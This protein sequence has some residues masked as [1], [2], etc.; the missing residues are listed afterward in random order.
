MRGF[1]SETS[2]RLD[3]D[4][5]LLPNGQ[6][7]TLA[8]IRQWQADLIEGR[9]DLPGKWSGRATHARS[10]YPHARMDGAGNQPAS[11]AATLNRAAC[12]DRNSAPVHACRPDV[13]G[14]SSADRTERTRSIW[15]GGITTG[16][17][18]P[19]RLKM[20]AC[21]KMRWLMMMSGCHAL[22]GSDGHPTHGRKPRRQR[23]AE[24]A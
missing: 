16:T 5:R 9:C 21:W 2:W 24:P 3:G 11:V 13:S 12:N 17:E 18:S 10:R 7:L 22:D 1:W 19:A 6:R 20:R 8:S 4:A 23:L 15:P 14:T